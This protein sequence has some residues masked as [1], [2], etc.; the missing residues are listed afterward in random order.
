LLRTDWGAQVG[1]QVTPVISKILLKGKKLNGFTK[2]RA[3]ASGQLTENKSL[4]CSPLN[5]SEK[6]G[7]R[8][9]ISVDWLMFSQ[10]TVRDVIFVTGK[11]AAPLIQLPPVNSTPMSITVG[12]KGKS[13][14]S[15]ALSG[16]KKS[17]GLKRPE[18]LECA[19]DLRDLA[20]LERSEAKLCV[21]GARL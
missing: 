3:R 17:V 4:Q 10:S 16:H 7:P 15:S 1:K 14:D 18:G 12:L 6:K 13:V 2:S 11:V 21:R 8:S 20:K 5:K 19:G 9:N